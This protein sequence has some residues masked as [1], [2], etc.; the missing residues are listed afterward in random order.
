MKR[1][2]HFFPS[3]LFPLWFA[4]AAT[5][6]TA[7]P[8]VC[9]GD[10]NHDR[11]TDIAELVTGIGIALGTMPLSRCPVIDLAG[12]GQASIGDLVQGVGATTRGCP[13]PEFERAACEVPLPEGQL[14]DHVDCGF[15]TLPE[16]RDRPSGKTIRLA[17]VI[18]RATGD[19]RADDPLVLLS[20]GPGD[21]ALDGFLPSFTAEF[22]AP[23]QA[24][25]DLVIFDQ[26]GTGRSQPAL[27]C[28]EDLTPRDSF[29][30]AL[31][32]AEEAERDA[33]NLIECHDRL[34][35]E[36]NDLAS[37]NSAAGALD[38][39]DV[40][41]ALGYQRFNIYGLSYGTRV[42]LTALRDLPN[43]RVRSVVL[44]SVLPPQASVFGADP[45]ATENSLELLFAACAA[46]TGCNAAYP[47]LRQVFFGL[48][49]QLN[50]APLALEPLDPGGQPFTFVVTGDRLIQLAGTALQNA[51][52]IP[53]IPLFTATTA[54][55]NPA[56]LKAALTPIGAPSLYSS[57][58]ALAVLCNEEILFD[59][60]EVVA[61]SEEGVDPI[62]LR[63]YSAIPYRSETLRQACAEWIGRPAAI[64]N[65][66]VRSD[67]PALILSGEY[68]PSTPPEFARLAAETLPNSYVF[69]FRGFGHVELLEQAAPTGPPACAMQVM[70]EFLG[71]PTGSPDRACVDALPAVRFAG[72]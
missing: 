65:E 29:R 24:T 18:L 68:D 46:D 16:N 45:A 20:G 51:D 43:E 3:F 2:P 40:M 48:Y 30:E 12:D 15:V 56:L 13:P 8:L 26:R 22:A 19:S 55:G 4:F 9:P 50:D 39:L 47:D 28:P 1:Y 61:M 64:E 6:A 7:V 38:V 37:Y 52:L 63:A 14:P 60:P 27:N 44:D 72:S 34:T 41:A 53:F 17:V 69:E 32:P 66:A 11:R 59:T 35:V 36:G 49:Q 25:R 71:D 58:L 33:R 62:F 21:W 42:A 57:G 5:T 54:S 31:T 70:A 10:C 67:V 23:L